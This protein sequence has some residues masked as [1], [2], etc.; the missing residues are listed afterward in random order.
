MEMRCGGD[1]MQKISNTADVSVSIYQLQ[2][3]LWI[4][5]VLLKNAFKHMEHGE[6]LT[7]RLAKRC[8]HMQKLISFFNHMHETYTQQEKKM[9][10]LLFI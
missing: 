3:E 10:L 8:N 4:Y 7:K 5:Y 9:L 6:V 1:C 2:G